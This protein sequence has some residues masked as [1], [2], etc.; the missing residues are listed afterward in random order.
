MMISIP[1]STR[2]VGETLFKPTSHRKKEIF[3]TI[4][5]CIQFLGRQ[6]LAL[7]GDGDEVDG[8]FMQLLRL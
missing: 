7:R 1:A 6:G 4:L 3:L 2:D 5:A 8:N